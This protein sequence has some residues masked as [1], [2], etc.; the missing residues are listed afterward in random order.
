MF[1]MMPATYRQRIFE[2]KAATAFENETDINSMLYLFDPIQFGQRAYK[3]FLQLGNP[4]TFTRQ[5][6]SGRALAVDNIVY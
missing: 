6:L 1:A 3:H 4:S 2:K 5:I